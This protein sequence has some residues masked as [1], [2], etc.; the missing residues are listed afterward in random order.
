LQVLAGALGSSTKLTG[1]IL[2]VKSSMKCNF[3]FNEVNLPIVFIKNVAQFR[4]FIKEKQ[5][6]VLSISSLKKDF[7]FLK[8]SFSITNSGFRLKIS[9]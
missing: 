6:I 9:I 1:Q 2:S 8:E 3:I 4:L 5:R 7:H